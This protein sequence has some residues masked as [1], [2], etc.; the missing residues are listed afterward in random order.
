MSWMQHLR[1]D[2]RGPGR[3]FGTGLIL[4]SQRPSRLDETIISQFNSF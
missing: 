4:I 2:A 3:K 1:H